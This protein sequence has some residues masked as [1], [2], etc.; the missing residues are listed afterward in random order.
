MKS[1]ILIL[2]IIL[3]ILLLNTSCILEIPDIKE[4]KTELIEEDFIL[5]NSKGYSV[6]IDDEVLKKLTIKQ[7]A[8]LWEIEPEILLRRMVLIFG[9]EKAYGKDAKILD[10]I[11]E[12]GIKIESIKDIAQQT[13][14]EEFIKTFDIYNKNMKE[15]LILLNSDQEEIFLT[16]QPLKVSWK[17]FYSKYSEKPSTPYHLD[18][19]WREDLEKINLKISEVEKSIDQEMYNNTR[20]LLDNI[21]F[22]WNNIY[23]RNNVSSRNYYFNKFYPYLFLA[24]NASK[25]GN[26][27]ILKEN[28]DEMFNI[29]PKLMKAQEGLSQARKEFFQELTITEWHNI[30]SVCDTGKDFSKELLKQKGDMLKQGFIEIYLEFE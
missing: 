4:K 22:K 17:K 15:L 12:S 20:I 19:K 29:W 7:T 21:T 6:K 27:E 16:S 23:E 25:T 30:K 5:K 18:E 26:I 28:C 10:I 8:D 13:K 11:K 1:N 2:T 3:I 24:F 9:L 14:D